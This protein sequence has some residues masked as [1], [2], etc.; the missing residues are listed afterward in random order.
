M[1]VSYADG[2]NSLSISSP[3]MRSGVDP[4]IETS[5]KRVTGNNYGA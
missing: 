3:N 2:A 1:L 4:L 5:V